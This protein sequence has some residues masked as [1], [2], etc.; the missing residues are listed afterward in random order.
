MVENSLNIFDVEELRNECSR[1]TSILKSCDR[2][3]IGRFSNSENR[4][5]FGKCELSI[6]FSTLKCKKST[7]LPI[8]CKVEDIKATA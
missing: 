4:R 1:G 3:S 2:K 6:K 8:H 5:L 7:L